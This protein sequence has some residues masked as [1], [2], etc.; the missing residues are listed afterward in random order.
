M[1]IYE[2]LITEHTNRE[3]KL[4][5]GNYEHKNFSQSFHVDAKLGRSRS[6]FNRN[7]IVKFETS[8]LMKPNLIYQL[9]E[10]FFC[11]VAGC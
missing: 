2:Q 1:F 11:T 10:T 5:E 3:Q 4:A 9:V 6:W 7:C 8:K